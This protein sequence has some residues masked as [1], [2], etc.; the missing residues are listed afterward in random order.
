MPQVAIRLTDDELAALDQMVAEH[1]F[2]SRT[3][4]IRDGI[5]RLRKEQEDRRI[6]ESY[7]RAYGNRPPTQE[8]IDWGETGMRLLAE[9][10]RDEPPWDFDE[11]EPPPARP[12]VEETL[13]EVETAAQHILDVLGRAAFRM[14]KR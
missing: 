6:A 9:L 3:A 1:H 7:E 11:E 4:A 14:P 12:A 8:E 13:R 5:A 2:A 10:T